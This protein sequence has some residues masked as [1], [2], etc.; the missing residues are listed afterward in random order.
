MASVRKRTWTYQGKPAEAWVVD[1]K[2]Y[3]GKRRSKQFYLKRDADAYR[4]QLGYGDRISADAEALWARFVSERM[5]DG[6]P[7]WVF[8]ADRLSPAELR[9]IVYAFERAAITEPK[10]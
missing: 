6:T 5:S 9:E 3:S 2:D 10:P 7:V 4:Y 8:L 1:Y